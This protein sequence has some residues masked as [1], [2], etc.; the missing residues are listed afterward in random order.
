M[1]PGT[2]H[3]LDRPVWNAL[4]GPHATLAEGGALARRY[5]PDIV[6]FAAARDDSAESL[7]ALAALPRPGEVM[8]LMEAGDLVLPPGSSQRSPRR[9]SRWCWRKRRSR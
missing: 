1:S 3:I 5:R 8:A 2:N 7:A 9:A 6:P 4:T